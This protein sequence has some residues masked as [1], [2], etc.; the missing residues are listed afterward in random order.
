M[1]RITTGTMTVAIFAI[2]FALVGAYALRAAL[3]TEEPAPP[4]PPAAVP[5]PMA[6]TDLPADHPIALGDIV[7]VPMNQ[8]QV[9]AL[10]HDLRTVMLSTDQIIGRY[11]RE[12]MKQGE[13]FLT[14]RLFRQGE[15]P[16]PSANLAPGLRAVTVSIDD[17]NSVGGSAVKGSIVDVIFRSNAR[18]ANERDGLPAI[19]ETTVVLLEGVEVLAVG[20]ADALQ[21]RPLTEDYDTV[22]L[23]RG[24]NSTQNRGGLVST[25]PNARGQVRTVTLG[26]TPEQAAVLQA[27]SGRGRLSL[28]LRNDARGGDAPR[29]P[30]TL[31][32]LLGIKLPT[33]LD[34]VEVYR[35]TSRHVMGF[36]DRG[37]VRDETF[38]GYA[39]SSIPRRGAADPTGKFPIPPSPATVG[40]DR[41]Q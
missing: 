39:G 18:P 24:A 25:G 4:A 21:D 14:T 26:V 13:P 34:R 32:N 11:L 10:G 22:D 20:R 15:A 7:L 12:P 3:T 28:A 33:P 38:G 30:I 23:A 36:D 27:V 31:E 29:G 19:P 41:T 17:L 6:A 2:L 16:D 40:G 37:F 35:G 8:E 9:Q 5:V 1:G